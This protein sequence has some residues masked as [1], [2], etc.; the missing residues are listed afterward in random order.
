MGEN[1]GNTTRERGTQ[2]L[3]EAPVLCIVDDDRS[4]VELVREVAEESGWIAYGFRRIEEG[5]RFLGWRRPELLILDD[6]LPDGR[7]GDLAR[8]LREDPALGDLPVIVC[9]AA[10][11]VRQE[12]IGT[13]APVIPKPFDLVEFERHLRGRPPLRSNSRDETATG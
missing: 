8:E 4:T 12:E 7:G 10:H 5:R 2:P 1:V 3:D 9:T 6:D 11:P 13:W